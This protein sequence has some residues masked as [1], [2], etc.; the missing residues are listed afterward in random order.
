MYHQFCRVFLLILFICSHDRKD[1]QTKPLVWTDNQSLIAFHSTYGRCFC[2]I[3][4]HHPLPLILVHK[5]TCMMYLSPS[6]KSRSRARGSHVNAQSTIV[7]RGDCSSRSVC[8][9]CALRTTHII[10]CTARFSKPKTYVYCDNNII[11]I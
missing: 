7:L 1:R 10:T 3:H 8:T 9:Y 6:Q 4:H 5:K 2:F 11:C